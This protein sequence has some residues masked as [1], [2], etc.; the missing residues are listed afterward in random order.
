MANINISLDID[1]FD[2]NW[3]MKL[4][5]GQSFK[6]DFKKC[7]RAFSSLYNSSP[8]KGNSRTN[9]SNQDVKNAHK[10]TRQLQLLH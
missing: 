3:N 6:Q 2:K 1:K 7:H 10:K 9:Y 5:I 8:V 4:K